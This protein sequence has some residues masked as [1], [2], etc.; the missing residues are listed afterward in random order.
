MYKS[1][2]F[3]RCFFNPFEQEPLKAYPRLAGLLSAIDVGKKEPLAEISDDLKNCMVR[4]VLAL[5]DPKSPLINDYP[6]LGTRKSAAADVAGFD[7]VA[8]ETILNILFE[9]DSEYLVSFIVSYLREVVQS[10]IWASVMADEQTFWEFVSRML[11][12][13][14]RTNKDKDDV[15]AVSLKTKLSED[16]ES[17]GQRLDNNWNKFFGEDDE[18]KKKAEKKKLFSPEEMAGVK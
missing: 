3:R 2:D 5:Y 10:R 14:G 1:G 13:I 17:I 7:R 4:Y 9:C 6:D 12:P 15:S 11:L 18:L 16:K 8:N